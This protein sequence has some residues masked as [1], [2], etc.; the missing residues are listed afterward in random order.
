VLEKD[1]VLLEMVRLSRIVFKIA[2]VG[3]GLCSKWDLV[4]V[5]LSSRMLVL[6]E[7]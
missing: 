1:F 2:F 5:G 3:G 6:E 7:D 4:R